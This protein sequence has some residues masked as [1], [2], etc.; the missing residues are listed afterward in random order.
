MSKLQIGLISFIGGALALVLIIYFA[1]RNGYQRCAT[2]NELAAEQQQA[3]DKSAII[4]IVKK[5]HKR[6]EKNE[7]VKIIIK[8]IKDPSG[9]ATSLIPVKRVNVML[10]AFNS[11]E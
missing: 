11:K 6:E 10:D 3:N 1:D 8:R 7:K 9:C 2:E 4:D 5:D